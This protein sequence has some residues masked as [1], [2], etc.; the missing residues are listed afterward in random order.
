MTHLITA[1]REYLASYLKPRP[2]ERKV[3]QQV[4]LVDNANLSD[5]LKDLQQS[6]AKFVLLGIPED[7]GPRANL[8]KGGAD[9]GWHAFLNNFV[10]L[11]HNEFIKSDELILLGHIECDD[12]Q[13]HSQTLDL[14]D[15]QGLAALRM[16]VEQ[17]DKRVSDVIELIGQS[18]LIPI[19][20]GGGHNNALPILQGMSKAQN[21]PLAVVNLDPHTD[22]RLLEGRHSGNGF[23]Y[24]A[25][26]QVMS[27]YFSL[28][29]HELKNSS[30]NLAS[31]KQYDFP[32]V[33]FQQIVNYREF[34]FEQAITQA[35]DYL[36]ASEQPIGIE[37][38]LDCISYMPASAYTNAGFSLSDAQ[39][40][41]HR[42]AQ[43]KRS[44]YL[45]L[46][47][48]AP[49]QHPAGLEAGMSDIGQG[50]ANLVCSFIQTKQRATF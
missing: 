37:L 12:L 22:F 3:G 33:S 46:A 40:Y 7:I 25:K 49:C 30:K 38:D 6:G 20:I 10:N 15:Q 43:L 21:Q 14:S 24:A 44:C 32:F 45:H 4:K 31:L 5:S 1:D 9:L 42:I 23:S 11:Q 47:E 26:Q 50:L 17:L 13:R 34:S 35:T 27:H 16:L 39:Y 48:G 41:I 8:G 2:N 28:G 36:D 29:M 19:V 18:Q